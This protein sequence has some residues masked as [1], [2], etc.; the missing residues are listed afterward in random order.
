[1]VNGPWPG[2]GGRVLNSRAV[3]IESSPARWAALVNLSGWRHLPYHQ[4]VR[5][6]MR[7]SWWT[8]YPH[9]HHVLPW[10]C[11]THFSAGV[12][13]WVTGQDGV[14]TM[15]KPQGGANGQF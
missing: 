9:L 2:C 8:G 10:Q 5:A 7:R 4:T 12:L 14:I 15:L 1:M 11:H 6:E 13:C 3:V